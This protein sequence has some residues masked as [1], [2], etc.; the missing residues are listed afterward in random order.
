VR[1]IVFLV[2]VY[3]VFGWLLQDCGYDIKTSINTEESEK[4]INIKCNPCKY[5]I[6]LSFH[7][8][9]HI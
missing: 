7:K 6:S 4:I 1:V 2:A 8:I 3:S 9:H 5:H